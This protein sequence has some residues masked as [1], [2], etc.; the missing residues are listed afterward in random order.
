MTYTT[1]ISSTAVADCG[2]VD[3]PCEEGSSPLPQAGEGVAF[4]DDLQNCAYCMISARIDKSLILW[5]LSSIS[6]LWYKIFF[7]C[8]YCLQV[9]T[10]NWLSAY[11]SLP[12]LTVGESH[13]E[14]QGKKQV[15][16]QAV[17]DILGKYFCFSKTVGLTIVHASDF[18]FSLGGLSPPYLCMDLYAFDTSP[19]SDLITAL[20]P[21]AQHIVI[22]IFLYM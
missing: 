9:I 4:T 20:Y 3:P 10:K 11:W 7:F 2:V 18:Q 14:D 12:V 15:C 16:F 1:W 17:K 21:I 22:Y 5:L 19:P 6:Y 13:C 8:C